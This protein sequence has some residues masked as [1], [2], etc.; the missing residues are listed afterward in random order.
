M[1]SI[2]GH[3]PFWLVL[4][5]VSR[6]LFIVG[7]YMVVTSLM[8]AVTMNPSLL[9]KL[10]TLMQ[11]ILV[12]AIL[13]DQAAGQSYF[14]SHQLILTSLIY[15]VLFTTIASGTHYFWLWIVKKEILTVDERTED[16][17]QEKEK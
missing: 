10:N 3:V 6:D 11:I 8:G 16:L 12:I 1:L 14:Q 5:V 7:G 13:A 4:A 2:L 17:E 15:V 9:S